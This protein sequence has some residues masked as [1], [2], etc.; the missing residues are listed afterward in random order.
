MTVGTDNII[1]LFFRE[2]YMSVADLNP[3]NPLICGRS[4]SNSRSNPVT[5]LIYI[6]IWHYSLLYFISFSP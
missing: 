6:Y 4:I 1:W 3:N 5:S 2:K